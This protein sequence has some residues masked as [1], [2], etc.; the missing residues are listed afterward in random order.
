MKWPFLSQGI[1]K[2]CFVLFFLQ[3]HVFSLEC[4]EHN[5]LS[6]LHL[7]VNVSHWA[8]KNS[9]VSQQVKIIMGA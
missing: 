2:F 3:S 6:K 8:K 5:Y 1:L 9:N 4:W 7:P